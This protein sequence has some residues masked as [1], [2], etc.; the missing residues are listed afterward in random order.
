M[1]NKEKKNC[2]F[3][4]EKKAS[5][6]STYNQDRN[7][8]RYISLHHVKLGSTFSNSAV[9]VHTVALEPKLD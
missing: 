5:V 1:F 7:L 8:K 6:L 4:T 3:N 9:A 2:K